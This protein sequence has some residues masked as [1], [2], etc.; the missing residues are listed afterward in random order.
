MGGTDE[1]LEG[2]R[3]TGLHQAE[4][5]TPVSEAGRCLQVIVSTGLSSNSVFSAPI[6]CQI[7]AYSLGVR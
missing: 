1:V 2:Q 5:G 3:R 7:V 4:A 6:V